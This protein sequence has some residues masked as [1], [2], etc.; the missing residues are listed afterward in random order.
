MEM[1]CHEKLREIF[2]I[3]YSNVFMLP[4][5]F[6][7]SGNEGFESYQPSYQFA[8]KVDKLK[9]SILTFILE[10]SQEDTA[11]Y[12]LQSWFQFAQKFWE[13]TD[14]YVGLTEYTTLEERNEDI[15]LFEFIKK[16][17]NENFEDA[18]MV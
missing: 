18:I 2:T 16:L 14:G 9:K 11:S 10:S 17:I 6:A 15:L 3:D 13:F 1:N 4:N 8:L 5:A 12:T 7:Q